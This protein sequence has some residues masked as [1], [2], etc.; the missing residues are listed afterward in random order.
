MRQS[1]VEHHGEDFKRVRRHQISNSYHD[2]VDKLRDPI[3]NRSARRRTRVF[4]QVA[5]ELLHPPGGGAAAYEPVIEILSGQLDLSKYDRARR[6][7]KPRD[8]MPPLWLPRAAETSPPAPERVEN[9]L[10]AGS[11]CERSRTGSR[12]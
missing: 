5:S 2:S 4:R 1:A 7:T 9:R 3:E 8:L 12:G 10:T 6:R 11:M